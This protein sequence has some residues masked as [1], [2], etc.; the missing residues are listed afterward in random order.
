MIASVLLVIY[1]IV[2]FFTLIVWG[3][4]MITSNMA[5]WIIVWSLVI[6]WLLC[7]VIACCSCD[8]TRWE[9][10]KH[11]HKREHEKEFYSSSNHVY[12][13]K[14]DVNHCHS[15]SRVLQ[16]CLDGNEVVDPKCT[17]NPNFKSVPSGYSER[18]NVVLPCYD[19]NSGVSNQTL[20]VWE[21][22][23]NTEVDISYVA[24]FGE[25][26]VTVKPS[27]GVAFKGKVGFHSIYGA[28]I[29]HISDC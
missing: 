23:N 3:V 17:A 7:I 16:I 6:Y 11:S 28:E 27:S 1:L 20:L 4:G 24:R 22:D 12:T 18:F 5:M 13:V 21:S 2:L 10:E 9:H 26:F 8:E 19:S 25:V 14:A 29:K 15:N